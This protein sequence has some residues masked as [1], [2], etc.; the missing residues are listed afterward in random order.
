MKTGMAYARTS[1]GASS[2]AKLRKA[3][4]HVPADVGFDG[5][6]PGRKPERQ[7]CTSI[8]REGSRQGAVSQRRRVLRG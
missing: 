5:E 1:K 2:R 8:E 7:Q 4:G 6:M 3:V